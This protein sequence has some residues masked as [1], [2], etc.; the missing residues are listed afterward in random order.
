VTFKR[1]GTVF[2]FQTFSCLKEKA[3]DFELIFVVNF[4]PGGLMSQN[5]VALVTGAGQGIGRAIA[6]ELARSGY[7]LVGNDLIYEPESSDRG[8]F[9]VM[10]RVE[11][12]E[13]QFIPVK[14]DISCLD[15]HE[16][17]I[18]AAF[19]SFG[20]LDVL[21]NNA[22]MAPDRRMDILETTP[23]S[24][25]RLMSVNAR[26]AFFLTQKAARRMI[27]EKQNDPA[28][29]KCIVFI[30][31]I[32]SVVSSTAR[33]EYC[34]S[35][36][37]LSQTARVF[38]DRLARENIFVYEIRPGIIKTDM[39]KAVKD[40]YDKLIAE[41]LIPQARWGLPEDVGRTVA[42]L[43]TGGVPYSTGAVLEVSGGMDIRR[44]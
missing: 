3:E 31:S 28:P 35:K 25:D 7:D 23:E 19:Q 10:M 32:S 36:A 8:L 5:K 22:G 21:V 38:A 34:V 29:S 12:L 20:R 11:E 40:K 6:I 15:D 41:G 14:G 18:E 43:A 9:E 24:Y 17:I 13:R 39:T 4:E 37:A 42:V 27:A 44:L 30:T 1:T 2:P 16:E 33:A 26:G